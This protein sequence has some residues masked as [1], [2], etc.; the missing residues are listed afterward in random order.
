MNHCDQWLPSYQPTREWLL[1]PRLR[2]DISFA[3]WGSAY[4]LGEQI[5]YSSAS[6][7]VYVCLHSYTYVCVCVCSSVTVIHSC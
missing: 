6:K 4:K 2:G 1:L 7:S 5:V 3:N